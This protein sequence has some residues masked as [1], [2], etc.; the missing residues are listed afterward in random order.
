MEENK[1]AHVMLDLETLGNVSNSVIA[2]IAAV[3]FN[4]ETGETGPQF[5]QRASIQ[6]CL[7]IGLTVNGSTIQFWMEQE[8]DARAELFKDTQNISAVLFNF[9]KFLEQLGTV[10][11]WGN[12]A[13]FDLGI[14]EN[15]YLKL[16]N[17][18][19]P[20]NY[21]L[22]RDVRTLVWFAPEIKKNEPFIGVKHNP[23]DDCLH[24]IKYC[25]KT[26]Q[27]IVLKV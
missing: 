15:A 23:I 13:R 26:W 4:I 21:S 14:L 20:W 7:D 8:N 11:M 19:I 17:K 18:Q 3:A 24:Q 27:K 1:F 2:S 16:G 22:E 6:S 5:Y 25:S 9:R 10:Y 12:S